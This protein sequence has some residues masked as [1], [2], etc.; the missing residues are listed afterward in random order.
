MLARLG[1]LIGGFLS[2]P[3]LR[4]WMAGDLDATTAVVRAGVGFAV[5]LA[6]MAAL[7]TLFSAY[8]PTSSAR[9]DHELTDITDAEIVEPTPM[10]G[11]TPD[12]AS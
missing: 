11:P 10:E 4:L 6:G 7:G 12:A 2:L 8:A 1:L 3:A 5:G 9:A